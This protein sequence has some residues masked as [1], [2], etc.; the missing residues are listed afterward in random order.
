MKTT[1][2]CLAIL[3]ACCFAVYGQGGGAVNFSEG[4]YWACAEDKPASSIALGSVSTFSGINSHTEC[5]K[6]WHLMS[7]TDKPQPKREPFDTPPQQW[8]TYEW[9]C[10]RGSGIRGLCSMY[11]EGGCPTTSLG[12][13]EESHITC[14]DP[15]RV[16]LTSEDQ[17]K[18]CYLFSLLEN[19]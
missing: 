12:M 14:A 2:I 17:V 8:A 11:P 5:E 15:K 10:C 7:W 19:R 16:L 1:M 13:V 6:G 3:L 9:Q 4:R 18:H